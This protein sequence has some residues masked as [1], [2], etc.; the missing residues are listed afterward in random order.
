MTYGMAASLVRD[1]RS[2][3]DTGTLTAPAGDAR[4][5]PAAVT[6]LAEAT[7][8]DLIEPGHDGRT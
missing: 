5:T 4:A 8:N 6:D 3:M 2:S 1:V 7:A